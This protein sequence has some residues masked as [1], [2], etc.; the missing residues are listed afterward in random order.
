MGQGCGDLLLTL[1]VRKLHN[2]LTSLNNFPV[3][4]SHHFK[5]R[6]SIAHIPTRHS[7]ITPCMREL[8]IIVARGRDNSIICYL[9]VE[10]IHKE[11]ICH[12]VET[13]AEVSDKIKKLATIVHAVRPRVAIIMGSQTDLPVMKVVERVSKEFNIPCEDVEILRR[14]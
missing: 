4:M 7:T 3:I 11:N 5:L 9:V 2:A 14:V 13:P 8:F 10:T 1:L 12:V 6:S